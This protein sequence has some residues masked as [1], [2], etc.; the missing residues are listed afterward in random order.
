MTSVSL[1]SLTPGKQ[2]FFTVVAVD[3]GGNSMAS[4]E[5]SGMTIANPPTGFAASAGNGSVSLTWSASSGAT[6][7]NVYEG[8]TSSGEGAATGPE[9]GE[10][11][12][13]HHRRADQWQEVLLHR[14]C[15]GCGRG[16]TGLR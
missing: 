14:R 12:E 10:R 13:R 6:S 2:Y 11:S 5:A 8:T 7:Y 3:A 15:G 9:R 16:F 1:T 4:T